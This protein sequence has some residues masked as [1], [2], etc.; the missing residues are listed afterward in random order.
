MHHLY[1]TL[2][3]DAQHPQEGSDRG[4]SD[5]QELGPLLTLHQLSEIFQVT[6]RTIQ[7]WTAGGT[8]PV[9]RLGRTTRYNPED[10]RYLI[11]AS[12]EIGE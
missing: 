12:T 7:R 4:H 9:V 1:P 8:L 3:L 11:R 10:I 5:I 2:P 6:P